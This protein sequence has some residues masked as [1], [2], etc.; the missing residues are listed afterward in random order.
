M[1][2]IGKKDP[3]APIGARGFKHHIQGESVDDNNLP[4]S[5]RRQSH[6]KPFKLFF[7]SEEKPKGL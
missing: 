5:A 1:E 3:L 6:S 7:T 2:M 4:G